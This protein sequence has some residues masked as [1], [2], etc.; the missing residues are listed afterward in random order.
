MSVMGENLKKIRIA[1]GLSRAKLEELTG[2]T[3]L[4]QKETGIRKINEKD[5]D[6]LSKQ[7]NCLKS[8]IVGESEVYKTTPINTKL[9]NKYDLRFITDNSLT[10]LN[11]VIETY[12]FDINFIKENFGSENI[13]LIKCH[14]NLMY[15]FLQHGDNI[16]I[17][18]SCKKF[19]NNGVFLLK[20]NGNGL[21]IKRAYKKELYKD[22]ITLSYDN[23]NQG[24]QISE[25]TEEK[26][27]ENLTGR[28]VYIGRSIRD[29]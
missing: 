9:L 7:L 19:I 11:D 13:A 22:I 26:F 20:E 3:N 8:D 17:D 4:Y 29:S 12:S 15:P 16:F 18:L 2:I 25:I 23:T 24:S 27:L 21:V 10:N 5:L 14:N 28:V 6:I 1:R